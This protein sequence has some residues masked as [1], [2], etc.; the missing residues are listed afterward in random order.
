MIMNTV[1]DLENA[2]LVKLGVTSDDIFPIKRE[3]AK[4]DLDAVSYIALKGYLDT[5]DW[6]ETLSIALYE[7][8]NISCSIYNK[9]SKEKRFTP[10]K[11]FVTLVNSLKAYETSTIDD[12]A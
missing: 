7:T 12:L 8:G 10:A 11:W 5:D 6:D 4:W 3:N 1:N 9:K 2:V